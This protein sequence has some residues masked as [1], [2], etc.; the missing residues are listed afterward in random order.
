[1]RLRE[2]QDR[3]ESVGYSFHAVDRYEAPDLTRFKDQE[4]YIVQV[5]FRG[6]IIA[7]ELNSTH[8]SALTMEILKAKRDWRQRHRPII[9]K[10]EKSTE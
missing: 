7:Q 3:L 6:K 1:M 5:I 9:G 8:Q 2:L 4:V 10:G